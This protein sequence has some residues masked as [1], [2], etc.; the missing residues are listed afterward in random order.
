MLVMLF[1]VVLILSSCDNEPT[2]FRQV[3]CIVSGE[4]HCDFLR[5][6][7]GYYPDYSLAF[8][9]S[10]FAQNLDLFTWSKYTQKITK[11]DLYWN[12]ASKI[13]V[14]DIVVYEFG[15][16]WLTSWSSDYLLCS[17]E[18]GAEETVELWQIDVITG[19]TEKIATPHN[20]PIYYPDI[21]PDGHWLTCYSYTNGSWGI[22]KMRIEQTMPITFIGEPIQLTNGGGYFPR[23]SPDGTKIAYVGGE[24]ETFEDY[25]IYTVSS[26]GGPSTQITPDGQT[27]F[28]WITWSA[29]GA[30]LVY[31]HMGDLWMIPSVGG[32]PE[33]I[34]DSPSPIPPSF[35]ALPT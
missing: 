9:G 26:E 21:S 2:G 23:W 17:V 30:W 6:N 11:L 8:W 16:C 31:S 7:P 27:S 34:T 5:W 35:P 24:G 19:L 22:W 28:N 13:P 15:F 12:P 25:N 33:Q 29:D 20:Q 32:T 3:T 10:D 1:S 14:D 18:V 4:Y